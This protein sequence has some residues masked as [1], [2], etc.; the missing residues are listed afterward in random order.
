MGEIPENR[1]HAKSNNIFNRHA[2]LPESFG[3]EP[4]ASRQ[5]DQAIIRWISAFQVP[6]AHET[7]QPAGTIVLLRRLHP[8]LARFDLRSAEFEFRYLA[9]WIERRIGEYIRRRFD[10]SERDEHN[11]IGNAVILA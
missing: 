3:G 6:G 2:I 10:V 4:S 7:G 9:E 8:R 5:H 1:P 11:A